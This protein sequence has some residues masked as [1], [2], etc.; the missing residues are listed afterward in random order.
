[1]SVLQCDRKGCRNV[2][3]DRHA[4]G[5][6]YICDEC[7]EELVGSGLNAQ[8]FMDTYKTDPRALDRRRTHFEAI[9]VK[10]AE[11]DDLK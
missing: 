3:C 4:R 10:R 9:F 1:M 11:T 7:F 2:L 5:Y 6:G 8:A